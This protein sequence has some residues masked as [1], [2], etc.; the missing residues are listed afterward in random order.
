MKVESVL[1]VRIECGGSTVVL[2]PDGTVTVTGSKS[3]KAT[4]GQSSMELKP[5]EVI[6][7][8]GTIKLNP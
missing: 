6:V 4:C 8:G 7:R 3:I 2:L 5:S 1:K